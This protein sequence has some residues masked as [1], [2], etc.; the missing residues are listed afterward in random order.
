[1]GLRR[2]W[3]G[4][5]FCPLMAASGICPSREWG[6]RALWL[7]ALSRQPSPAVASLESH[8]NA[9]VTLGTEVWMQSHSL[10]FPELVFRS[11]R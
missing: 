3:Q 6:T 11:Q 2:G 7:C 8:L 9:V 1:M 10:D 5:K 4:P